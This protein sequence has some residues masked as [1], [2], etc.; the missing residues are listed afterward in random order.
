MSEYNGLEIAVIG[1]AGRFPGADNIEEFWSNLSRSVE[2]VDFFHKEELLEAGEDENKINDPNYVNANAFLSDKEHFDEAFF[3]YRPD[4]AKVMDPQVRVLHECVWHAIEDAGINLDHHKIPIGLFLGT[5]NNFDWQVLSKVKNLEGLV[6]DFSL[7]PLSDPKFVSSRIAYLLD[8]KGPAIFNDTACSTSLVNIHQA[9]RSLLMADCNVAIAG[10]ASIKGES[11]KGY[12]YKE[13]MISSKDGHCRAFDEE[14]S[15]CISGEGVGVVVLKK[16]SKA[17]EDGDQVYAIVK[18]SSINNDGAE[19]VNYAAPGVNGQAEVLIKARKM[20]KV[21]PESIGYIETH[22]TGTILGDPIEIEALK[23]AFGNGSDK[24]CAIGS[25]KTNIGHLDAAAGVA[26]FIKTVLALK[27]KK[28]P[29]SLNFSSPNPEI[30]FTKSPFYVNT[31]L[32]DWNKGQYPL[33]AGVSSFGIGGTNAHVIL[34][35]AP[36]KED[37]SKLRPYELLTYSAKS[38]AGLKRNAASLKTYLNDNAQLS[39]A[40]AVYTLN[41]G[42]SSF[43]FRKT[44]VAQTKADL[45]KK[46][47]DL[48]DDTSVVTPLVDKSSVVFMFPGQGAQYTGMCAD[49]YE[50]ETSFRQIVDECCAIIRQ[51]SGKDLKPILFAEDSDG[52]DQ[53]EFTQ[54]ALFVMEYALAVLLMNLGIRPDKMIGHSIGEYVAACIAGVFSLA[55]ALKLVAKRGEL[56]QRMP[57]GK[58][59]SVMVSENELARSIAL[60]QE[61]DIAAIN[62]SASVVLAGEESALLILQTELEKAEIKSKIINTSHA[63]H[64]QMMS[65]M[66][67]EFRAV[68][69]NVERQ[70]SNIPIVSNLTGKVTSVSELTESSY[71]VDQ[72]R[73]TVKFSEGLAELMTDE[74]LVF[75]EVGPGK[76]LGSFV[77]AHLLKKRTH[78]IV[79][80][81]SSKG[82][83]TNDYETFLTGV[84]KLWQYGIDPEWT[85]F[86]I[87]QGRKKTSIPGYSFEKKEYPI[88]VDAYKTISGLIPE[89]KSVRED[90]SNWFY[91]PTWKLSTKRQSA[92]DFSLEKSCLIFM[93]DCGLSERICASLDQHVA[94]L[95]RVEAGDQFE[96]KPSGDYKINPSSEE[97]FFKLF[98]ELATRGQIPDQVI[99]AWGIMGQGLSALSISDFDSQLETLLFVCKGYLEQYHEQKEVLILTSD[100]HDFL[101]K[102]ALNNV[103]GSFASCLLKVI[104]QEHP[105][106]VTGLIDVAKDELETPALLQ[107]V[108][109]E[110]GNPEPGKHIALR[111]SL[112]WEQHFD[113]QVIPEKVYPTFKQQGVYLITG[114]LGN[115]GQTMANYLANEYRA[116]LILVGKT[117]LPPRVEWENV[118]AR[119]KSEPNVASKIRKIEELEEAGGKVHYAACDFSSEVRLK[120][121]LEASETEFGP[122][123][124]VIHAAGTLNDDSFKPLTKVKRKDLNVQ[125]SPKRNGIMALKEAIG[126]RELDFCV[127]T[128][129]LSTVLGGIN[130]GVYAMANAFVDRYVKYHSDIGDLQNWMSL[131]LDGID[132]TSPTA[133]SIRAAELPQVLEHA[134]AFRGASQI[135]VSTEDLNTRLNDWVKQLGNQNEP[136]ESADSSVSDESMNLKASPQ[137]QMLSLWQDFFGKAEI[138]LD[139]DFF[140]IGGDSLKAL[141][142]TTRINK[143]FRTDL[144]LM[145]FFD[146]SSVR[147]LTEFIAESD[148]R[149]YLGIEKAKP[150]SFYEVSSA[151]Q[152]LHFLYEFDKDS[153]AYNLPQ[154]YQL[155]GKLDQSRLK[156]VFEQIIERHES[157]RTSFRNTE[158]GVV[159]Y[160]EKE[161]PFGIESFEKGDKDVTT[162]LKQFVR[163]FDLEFPP[164]LRVGVLKLEKD[165][166][167]LMLDMHHIVTD[168][169][170][171]SILIQE[172]IR[173]YNGEE[174]PN[175]AIQYKDYSEWQKSEEHQVRLEEVK[176]F[177][178]SEFETNTSYLELPT[179]FDRPVTL[180]HTGDATS[181]SIGEEETMKLKQITRE[182]GATMFMTILSA[183]NIFLSKISNQK[184]I[185]IGTP[186]S[187]RDHADLE[188][189]VGVFVNTL[190][191]RNEVDPSLRFMDFLESVKDKSLSSFGNQAY[192][193][194]QLIDTL[195][196]A[197]NTNRNP[198]FDVFF[199]LQNIEMEDLRLE[200]MEVTPFSIPS[201]TSNFDLNLSATEAE[202]A[203]F[204]RLEYSTELF[205]LET[206][207]K[208]IAYF[209]RI[210]AEI[211]S[212]PTVRISD[213]EILGQI[214]KDKLL[215][216]FNDTSVKYPK[217]KTVTQVFEEQVEKGPDEIAVVFDDQ[218]V[219]YGQLN[220]QSNQL[221][222]YLKGN[223]VKVG[224]RIAIYADR[225]IGTIVCMLGVMKA[226]GIY[227]PLD[228]NAPIQRLKHVLMELDTPL[229]LSAMASPPNLSLEGLNKTIEVK[230]LSA[231]D[232]S[233]FPPGNL[234]TSMSAKDLAYII[235]T[236]GSTGTPKGVMLNH[237]GLVNVVLFHIEEL[238]MG[239][240][241]KYLQFMSLLFDGSVLDMVK[242]LLS[243]ATL[244]LPTKQLIEDPK[245]LLRYIDEQGVTLFTITPSYLSLLDKAKMDSVRTLITAGEACR[246]EDALYY[247]QFKDFYNGYGPTEVTINATLYKVD[248]TKEYPTSI[249]IGRPSA[250]KR[251]YVLDEQL[252]L[253]PSGVIGEMYVGGTGLSEGYLN[254]PE[255]TR[256]KFIADPYQPDQLIYKTGDIGKWLQNGNLEFHGRKDRQVKVGGY[257]IETGEIETHLLAHE[258]V[259]EAVVTSRGEETD[260]NLV[261]YYVSEEELSVNTLR[262]HLSHQLPSYMIPAYF[263]HL[264]QMPLTVN[265]KVDLRALPEPEAI[266][267]EAYIAPRN[268]EEALL[269]EIWQSVLSI[270]KIGIGDNFFTVGGDSIKSIQ[271]ISRLRA[272]GYE[273]SVKDIFSSQTIE[274]L[275]PRMR[276]LTR[277]VDQSP[278]TGYV[279]LT[280]IQAWF[281]AQPLQAAHHFNQSV[282]LN[283]PNGITEATVRTIFDQL[284]RHHDAFRMSYSMDTSGVHQENKGI[285]YPLTLTYADLSSDNSATATL[286]T[287][288]QQEQ[289]GIDLKEGPL[290]RLGLFDMPDGSRLQVVVHHLVMDGVSWRVLFEDI[291]SLYRQI[292]AG[293][294]LQLPPKTDSYKSWSEGLRSYMKEETFKNNLSYWQEAFKQECGDIPKDTSTESNRMCDT[295]TVHFQL[296]AAITTDLLTTVHKPFNTQ[297]NDLLLSGL[298]LGAHEHYGNDSLRVDLEG[299][300]REEIVPDL[301][302][303]RTIGW[304]TSIYSVELS[305]A[306]E[307]S[308]VLKGVKE[309]L[310]SIP[311]NGADYLLAR[312]V[313]Q[314]LPEVDASSQTRISFNYLGQ[315]DGDTEGRVFEIASESS[316]LNH[317]EEEIRFH[318]WD[319]TGMV[320]EGQ[321]TLSLTYNKEAYS[322]EKVRS[323]MSAY[324]SQLRSLITYCQGY[325][326]AGRRELTPSDLSY[327]GLTLNQL[328]H[329]QT[330]YRL[331]D[332]YPLS[333]MQEGLL[334]HA[335]SEPDTS[336]YFEQVSY[337]LEGQVD[338]SAVEQSLLRLASRY[339]ILRTVFVSGGH[340]RP[341]QVVQEDG[342]IG[343]TYEDLRE[344]VSTSR[345]ELE[346]I[347]QGYR[348]ADRS[349]G[350]DLS[351]GPLMRVSIYRLSEAV[352]EF[353][354]SH[355]H[356]LMDGW[357]MSILINEF[358]A[359]YSSKGAQQT[360]NL[361]SV[362]PYSDYI[363]WLEGRDMEASSAYWSKYLSGYATRAMLPGKHQIQHTSTNPDKTMTRLVLD[364]E[365]TSGLQEVCQGYGVTLNTMIQGI[366]GILLSRYNDTNDVVFGTVVSG[367]PAEVKGI[368]E[369]VGLFI[370]TIPVRVGYEQQEGLEAYLKRLQDQ[371]LASEPHHYQKLSEIQSMSE[372]GQDLIDHILVFENYPISEQIED[373]G[374]ETSHDYVVS[375]TQI[376]EETHYDL[377][378]TVLPGTSMELVFQYNPDRYGTDTIEDAKVHFDR[379]VD[380]IIANDSSQ[381]LDIELLTGSEKEE[382]L[383]QFNATKVDYPKDQSIVALFEQQA[384]S[385]GERVALI[386]GADQITYQELNDRANQI[387]RTLLQEGLSS[388]EL[389]GVYAG[390]TI[391]A[392]T[393]IL[394][395]LKAGG[396][397]LPLDMDYPE[398]RLKF[399]LDDCKSRIVLSEGDF[400]ES[401]GK[402]RLELNLKEIGKDLA[403]DNLTV[404]RTS[405]Q[406]A[407]VMYT[408][409]TTGSPKGVM[410]IEK[411]ISR[412]LFGQEYVALSPNT[413]ILGTGKLVFDASTFE[414]WGT[415][416]HGGKLVLAADE[417]L[418]DLTKFRTLLS[419]HSVNTMWLT[420]SLFNQIVNEDAA[421]FAEMEQLIVG[422][423]ALSPHHINLTRKL[424]PQLQLINGYGPTEGTTF[425]ICH[426]IAIDYEA[427]IPLGVPINNT[428]IYVLDRNLQIQPKGVV[429]EL[430]IGG[431][432]LAR[433]YLNNP[434]LTAEKFVDDPFVA[435]QTCY[436]TGDL[437][438]WL[439]NG[440]IEFIGRIDDQIKLRGF[441]IEL[442]EIENCL[443]LLES[444]SSAAVMMMD[445]EGEKVLIAY[446]VSTDELQLSDLRN[447]LAGQLPEY[448]IP[449]QFIYLDQLPIT[450]NGKLDRRA[451]PTINLHDGVA[452]VA[453]STATQEKLVELWAGVLKLEADQISVTSNFFELGGHSLKAMMLVNKI[454]KEFGVEIPIKEVFRKSTITEL[455]TI[456]EAI[457]QLNKQD[458]GGKEVQEITI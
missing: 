429:G 102:P 424:H 205:Q 38:V 431:D 55:D 107:N 186:V 277:E 390:R 275:A 322:E 221:A 440:E 368:E 86:Y 257:R 256:E 379:I 366:W 389:V 423:E 332:V 76:T 62:S 78:K 33:R 202:K 184:D 438:R 244:V 418:L 204:F 174:L 402:E 203:V 220:K 397:Y 282:L 384:S 324:Q 175:Q 350:F 234:E 371:S 95:V 150:K 443:L 299:H 376:Y 108:L 96:E 281:F 287:L 315:F 88:S 303:S 289:E 170:S 361:P 52:I 267:Q 288:C 312:Y 208:F 311:Q 124:G 66:L 75:V 119:D 363:M 242:S 104:A 180:N 347:L 270:E 90:L 455:E 144:A 354:W 141:T 127:T 447:H 445:R 64:S 116:H 138:A 452:Y 409:G 272:S 84:G 77:G 268:P 233:E 254:N 403:K 46:L 47:D 20:A 39:L 139:D 128:S 87:G 342:V 381:L 214:E 121:I 13:G 404:K 97:D 261:G 284:Q 85:A 70:A 17:L 260:I 302:I 115:L 103:S 65:G 433:G 120:E 408:S 228:P 416:L 248:P 293:K 296:D 162:I 164:L 109:T 57:K 346:E 446:Y 395:I 243:G 367:R 206:I 98:E 388:E 49:L 166:H 348:E 451:L 323:F 405:D 430:Y 345:Q 351:K 154:A 83:H 160:I 344:E 392:V 229:I 74:H 250:N 29:A 3:G 114:G 227:V 274:V 60:P 24:H 377:S 123:D 370:N 10:G 68:V 15:G 385:N 319:F 241:D 360:L 181:F 306:S 153:I 80:L 44:I 421:V 373:D 406:L 18:G 134:L 6:D 407:Y 5:S 358:G 425:S 132:Y 420:S 328:S 129:S 137:L 113:R 145:D 318:D 30:D 458:L 209:K 264:D 386:S 130:M 325:V 353:V 34:E 369:M 357:C 94:T 169:T 378:V 434:G 339:D 251:I 12:L 427:N 283:F 8:L 333:P 414:V 125:F 118:L 301:D 290:L 294:S 9:C 23:L 126:D 63:F 59:L 285:P 196:L 22:G 89:T 365:Q 279:P 387:A 110:L 48:I 308:A 419:T 305:Y 16:L 313:S 176:K 240:G 444:I 177:W 201:A 172:F 411:N 224:D 61:V 131:D 117:E 11:K 263:V 217:D 91:A 396:A 198:L 92:A 300:G 286:S 246:K 238:N 35:E 167:L 258:W 262:R 336:Y 156:W 211:A 32:R 101:T 200:Q 93:D 276:L 37:T 330:E 183:F 159:Q 199:M 14:A 355:H 105:A 56:M 21:A 100:S 72:I 45:Q 399:M 178:I 255:L 155:K 54:P 210:V 334:F 235:Y 69:D 51:Q 265:G 280:G 143:Q 356:I 292:E 375:G 213:I 247:S 400:P 73:N 391:A 2:S 122:I 426:R 410:V 182:S 266:A 437:A 413:T 149:D 453:A 457:N 40:D 179:D 207:Q 231:I 135:V 230:E 338:Q 41:I 195:Q 140:E 439:P 163:P 189:V 422:G 216:E 212:D 252:Q 456:I 58:M 372:L 173:L 197:R 42:R 136:V 291:D 82:G 320:A 401:L 435:G 295:R 249:P 340:D 310:R 448:M 161:I 394:G 382:L 4:E 316:G 142:L 25:V 309:Q 362:L 454:K 1:M 259:K 218:V 326:E 449:A 359:L 383:Y 442:P 158:S 31:A 157:L 393:G 193:Y 314:E 412:L 269:C 81:I 147:S 223:G 226:G 417:V 327:K 349:R 71:W 36:V 151:Q 271:I 398:E 436:R 337:R 428:H 343:Y 43:P 432:G 278:V 7:I 253:V 28:I 331:K 148:G 225:S 298:I 171:T 190:A 352:Y 450:K 239:A 341:L 219:T 273:L 168:G 307:M 67:E 441:R 27:H 111:N 112:R 19:K 133:T 50:S 321:L 335:L 222:C 146:N 415:L 165:D 192:P 187:G 194:E 188:G 53:T 329:L 185:V 232:L 304:F 374:E 26:G 380:Q 191:I 152:R 79:N 236:S 237:E 106:L 317:S 297:I 364:R 245:A 215:R 99:Y